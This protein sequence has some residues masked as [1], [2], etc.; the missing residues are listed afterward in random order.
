VARVEPVKKK[1]AKKKGTIRGAEGIRL[2]DVGGWQGGGD[3]LGS[4]ISRANL[5]KKTER[6]P[7]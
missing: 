5:T 3:A 4:L 6:A 1:S 7:A 2:R